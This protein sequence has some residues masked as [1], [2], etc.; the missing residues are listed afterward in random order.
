[1]A[2]GGAE[3][4]SQFRLISWDIV[5]D[6]NNEPVLIEANLYVGELEFHQL[7]NGPIFGDETEEILK[8]IIENPKQISYTF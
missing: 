6:C 4:M 7:N 5:L 2:A 8:E 1:M 3:R